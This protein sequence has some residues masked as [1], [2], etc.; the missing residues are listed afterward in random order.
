MR[1]HVGEVLALFR[2]HGELSR[3]DVIDLS[4]LSR[5]TVNQR[6]A[7]LHSAGLIEEIGGGESTGGRPSSRFALNR[8]RAVIL[9]A[10]I[11]ATG[12]VA[13]VCD[14]AG[15]PL[16]HT[17]V[18]VNVWDGPHPVLTAVDAAFDELL[19]GGGAT[20]ADEVWGIGIGV[21]GPVEFAAGRVVNPPIMTGWDRFDIAGWFAA[22]RAPVVVEN[23][24]NSRAVAEARLRR[25][26][27]LISLKVGTGIG[28]GLVFNSAIIRGGE[29]AAGDIGHTRAAVADGAEGLPCRCGNVGCV[30]AYAS[31]WAIIRDL[32]A[33]GAHA[34]DVAAVVGLVRQGDLDAVR[35]VRQ[36]GRVLGDAVADLVSIL[37]PETIVLSGQLAECGEV[38]LSGVR[39]RVYQRSQPLATR[40]LVIGVSELGEVAGVTGLALITADRILGTDQIDELLERID[41]V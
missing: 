25:H 14:L 27:N 32:D 23:D 35:L 39:E 20:G 29:G 19:A 34:G 4:G 37:N 36:A 3:T 15:T 11:G 31:G 7:A 2:E 40:N 38:L 17:S 21:P 30:E 12:F 9:T 1:T 26:D 33:L 13:A 5:S 24:A 22:R 8:S 41:T 6:L 28:S 10:D 18:S 16:R